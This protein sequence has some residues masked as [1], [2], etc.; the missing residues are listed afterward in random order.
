[1]YVQS[2][3]GIHMSRKKIKVGQQSPW[4]WL[5][6]HMPNGVCIQTNE[7]LGE[8]H[9]PNQGRDKPGST[10]TIKPSLQKQATYGMFVGLSLKAF[11]PIQRL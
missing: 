1:M 5:W 4:V 10:K 9:F 3:T 7:I 2:C 8:A 6:E 11:I